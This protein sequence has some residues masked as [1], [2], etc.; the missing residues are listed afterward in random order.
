MKAII[1]SVGLTEIH[2]IRLTAIIPEEEWNK[3]PKPKFT[4]GTTI[5]IK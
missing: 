3:T 2:E 5:E 1:I 4:V